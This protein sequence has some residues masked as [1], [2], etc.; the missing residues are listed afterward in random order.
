ML[1]EL[2]DFFHVSQPAKILYF[3]KSM[4]HRTL[5]I[6]HSSLFKILE[7]LC[8]NMKT[9]LSEK[10]SNDLDDLHNIHYRLVNICENPC[11]DD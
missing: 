4:Y 1:N 3:T 10:L 5:G 9:L 7:L 11:C 2:V 6:R 8:K